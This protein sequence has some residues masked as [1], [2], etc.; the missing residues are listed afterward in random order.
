MPNPPCLFCNHPITRNQRSNICA[1]CKS[2]AHVECAAP[3]YLYGFPYLP[4]CIPS[5]IA[6]NEPSIVPV[7][8]SPAT[9]VPPIA[10]TRC[11]TP[12][13]VQERGADPTTTLSLP[14]SLLSASSTYPLSTDVTTPANNSQCPPTQ[15]RKASDSSSPTNR[16]S[17]ISRTIPTKNAQVAPTT[18]S[19][20]PEW[21]T[22]Y[23]QRQNDKLEK[24]TTHLDNKIDT[25]T[26]TV[27]TLQ[28]SLQAAED[29]RKKESEEK[30]RQI[31]LLRSQQML[32]DDLE[33]VIIGL[34]IAF[35]DSYEKATRMLY[36]ALGLSQNK[37]PLFDYREWTP[38][39]RNEASAPHLTK[40]FIIEMPTAKARK[41]LLSMGPKLKD[42][43]SNDIWQMGDAHNVSI[44]PLWPTPVHQ[45]QA[46]ATRES[47]RLNFARPI[48]KGL[49][50]CMRQTRTSTPVPIYSME[51]LQAFLEKYKP[52]PPS[53][54]PT[55][56][57]QMQHD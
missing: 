20:A 10:S 41:D 34:P 47:K 53:L 19:E 31:E 46:A 13:A 15:K 7:K 52:T 48:I 14:S 21:F 39:R 42:I 2:L 54:P 8:S 25:L 30:N 5:S 24:Q 3:Q 51:E 28:Q 1:R 55:S 32:T 26:N 43:H 17:K 44:R 29:E 11:A 16:E 45:L 6:I 38:S 56:L 9:V 4:C 36:T 33:V 23:E 12:P 49:V 27:S 50:V 37:I 22:A 18:M 40:A 35:T 57:S